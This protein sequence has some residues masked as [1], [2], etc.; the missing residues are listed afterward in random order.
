MTPSS[1]ILT[2][3]STGSQEQRSCSAVYMYVIV[4]W[5]ALFH[6][7]RLCVSALSFLR[8]LQPTTSIDVSNKNGE[9]GVS[10][11]IGRLCVVN[12]GPDAG[13]LCTI[14]D[15]IDISRVLVDGPDALTGVGRQSIPAKWLSLTPIVLKIGRGARTSTLTKRMEKDDVIARYA[16]TS[17]GKKQA[18]KDTRAKLGDFERFQV[19]VL[20]K[21]R[22]RAVGLALG[23][24][25]RGK[26]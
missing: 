14:L 21:Q 17:W 9:R 5:C 3:S 1:A 6:V 23:K 11:Q 18:T 26:K 19:M 2:S 16:K 10:V 20:R 13:K 8:L 25:K 24:L 4:M 7:V 22:S 12:Y 15:V